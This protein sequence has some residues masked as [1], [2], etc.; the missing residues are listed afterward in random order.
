MNE[1]YSSK[2]PMAILLELREIGIALRHFT[3]YEEI[4]E[5]QYLRYANKS[6]LN[7]RELEEIGV[8]INNVIKRNIFDEI[9]AQIEKRLSPQVISVFLFSKDDG[10]IRRVRLRG[11][12]EAKEEIDENV[13]I[14]DE[15]YM[16]GE[17]FSGRSMVGI[18]YGT[19]VIEDSFGD[20]ASFDKLKYG[21]EYRSE[22]GGLICGISV[23]LFG[24]RKPFGTIEVI[25]KIDAKTKERIDET[26]S[27]EEFLW[28]T[29]LASHLS[30]SLSRLKKKQEDRLLE[31]L[32]YVIADPK[33][34]VHNSCRDIFEF[35]AKLLVG[36][37]TPYK[38]AIIRLIEDNHLVVAGQVAATKDIQFTGK[39][40]KDTSP[41]KIGEGLVG[42][43]A[44]KGE[45]LPI[46]DIES[47]IAESQKDPN[48]PRFKNVGWI[49]DNKLKSFVCFPLEY[50]GKILGTLS[51]FIGYKH[52]FHLS[53][54]DFLKRFS[55]CLS[56]GQK[57]YSLDEEKNLLD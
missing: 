40:G 39:D 25:N 19:L 1:G 42:Q 57:L 17:S 14:C 24:A 51:L 12:N 47:Y 54:I 44:E 35:A 32:T 31:K 43:V 38:V 45:P 5:D 36:E 23:P 50:K 16:P 22:L 49:T 56:L 53:D 29:L 11:F 37:N 26:F 30:E 21:E 48:K 20:P 6:M 28:L 34:K 46:D 55:Y 3:N 33:G 41:R 18:P 13:F 2:S 9:F 4:Y 10:K 27:Q 7:D 52:K 15:N 8:F